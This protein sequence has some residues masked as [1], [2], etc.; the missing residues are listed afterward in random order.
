MQGD[1]QYHGIKMIHFQVPWD[2]NAS[3]NVKK[4]NRRNSEKIRSE[5]IF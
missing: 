5:M 3:N 2:L 1:T 4:T